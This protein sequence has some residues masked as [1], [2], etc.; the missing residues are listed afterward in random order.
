MAAPR[1][2]CLTL[3]SEDVDFA[4]FFAWAKTGK[5]IAARMAMIAI[6]TSSSMR[7]N[8]FFFREHLET[9]TLEPHY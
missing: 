9:S 2:N 4:D 3:D 8:A 6:T 1:F 7:V 5:R